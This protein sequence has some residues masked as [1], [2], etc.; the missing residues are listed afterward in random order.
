MFRLFV[1]LDFVSKYDVISQKS[2]SIRTSWKID[3]RQQSG[4]RQVSH[5]DNPPCPAVSSLLGA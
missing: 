5:F 4:V 1:L 2:R 3:W